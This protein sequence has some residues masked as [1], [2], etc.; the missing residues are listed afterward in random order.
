M[1]RNIFYVAV[2]VILLYSA[3]SPANAGPPHYYILRENRTTIGHPYAAT[4][5]PVS[6]YTYSYGYFGAQTT[7]YNVVHGGY[8]GAYTRWSHSGSW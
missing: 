3:M 1:M 5:T 4:V 8:S 7:R 2:L 6:R